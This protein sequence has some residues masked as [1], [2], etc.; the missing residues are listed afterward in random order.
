VE[1]N[2]WQ[3][4]CDVT[5]TASCEISGLLAEDVSEDGPPAPE[6]IAGATRVLGDVLIPLLPGH[7][8]RDNDSIIGRVCRDRKFHRFTYQEYG[9][10]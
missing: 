3:D 1:F 8:L 5:L 7:V 4:P 6:V 2:K 9:S 10:G